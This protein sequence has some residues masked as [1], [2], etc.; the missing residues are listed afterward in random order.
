[1]HAGSVLGT[2][3]KAMIKYFILYLNSHNHSSSLS[4][5]PHF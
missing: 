5:E 1:M 4:K 2:L 3:S